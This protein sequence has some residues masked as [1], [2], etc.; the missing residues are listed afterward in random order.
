MM[1]FALA[2]YICIF[3]LYDLILNWHD[4]DAMTQN[5][6]LSLTHVVYLLKVSRKLHPI[7]SPDYSFSD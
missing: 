5:V 1:Q 2:C 4:L 3:E 6:V 7:K